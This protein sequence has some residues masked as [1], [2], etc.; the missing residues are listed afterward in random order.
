MIWKNNLLEKWKIY[1][2]K[3]TQMTVQ[4]ERCALVKGILKLTQCPFSFSPSNSG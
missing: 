1:L 4:G 3:N 2:Y